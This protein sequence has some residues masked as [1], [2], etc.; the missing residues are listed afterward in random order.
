VNDVLTKLT[1]N[2][3]ADSDAAALRVL[4]RLRNMMDVCSGDECGIH[5]NEAGYTASHADGNGDVMV[6]HIRRGATE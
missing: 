6:I 3:C 2:I 1:I 5:L 4:A